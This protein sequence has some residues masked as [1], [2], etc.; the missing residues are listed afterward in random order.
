MTEIYIVAVDDGAYPV[1]VFSTLDKAV[2][3]VE[4]R[5]VKDIR[6][7]LYGC[8]FMKGPLPELTW[9]PGFDGM[10]ECGFKGKRTAD[11]VYVHWSSCDP[12]IWTIELDPA[13]LKTPIWDL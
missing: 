11:G 3:V 9:Q 7:G 13:E 2:A 12:V 10:Y 1:G 8:Q 4:E 5:I 6:S